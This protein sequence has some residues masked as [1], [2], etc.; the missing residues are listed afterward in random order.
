MKVLLLGVDVT[1]ASCDPTLY[2]ME[3]GPHSRGDRLDR[4]A[5]RIADFTDSV[6]IDCN[7]IAWTKQ[8]FVTSEDHDPIPV[9]PGENDFHHVQPE[10]TDHIMPKTQ[11]SPYPEHETYFEDLKNQGI[12]T[13]VLMGFDARNCIYW[14]IDSLI[15]NGFKVIVPEE[16][17]GD[18]KGVHPVD[19]LGDY[20]DNIYHGQLI[21]TS[22]ENA[23]HMLHTKEEFRLPPLPTHTWADLNGLLFGPGS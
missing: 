22:S 13:V 9:R 17:I 11:M 21:I 3:S 8:D 16:L 18:S 5:S 15:Q 10:A 20:M 4:T 7:A 2:E 19:A 12:D 14:T 1:R 23:A 6:R